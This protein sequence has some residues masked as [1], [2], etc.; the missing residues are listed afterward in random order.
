M[1]YFFSV[2]WGT[3]SLRVRLVDINDNSIT[4]LNEVRNHRG[5]SAVYES[6]RNKKDTASQ[7]DYFLKFLAP[8]L[9]IPD[10]VSTGDPVPVV[11]SGM[12]ASGIGIRE[13]PYTSL[14]FPLD[15][16]NL[17]YE[18]I[19]RTNMFDHEVLLLSGLHDANDVMR[20]EEVQLMGLQQHQNTE[21]LFILPGTHSKHIHV[22]ENNILSFKTYM[23]GELFQVLSTYSLLKNSIKSTSSLDKEA[24]CRGLKLSRGNLLHNAFSIRASTLLQKADCS[25]NYAVLSGLLIGTELRDIPHL[26]VPVFLCAHENLIDSYALAIEQLSMQELCTIIPDEKV[27]KSVIHGQKTM[28]ERIWNRS[29]A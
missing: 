28:V 29:L 26:N 11:I 12:A 16:S 25:S 17:K 22:K 18:I 13:V 20:G 6:F 19:P 3:S 9:L 4:V 14:P 27:D 23:T 1:R 15:G 21:A 10:S 2:D 7:Q 5:C 8:Y 24:F